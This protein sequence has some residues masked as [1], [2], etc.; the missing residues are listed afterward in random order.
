MI[1]VQIKPLSV[2]EAWQGKRFKTPK[3][4]KYERDLLFLLPKISLPLPPYRITFEF[5]LSSKLAD[6]D[7]PIK[8]TQ[9]VMQKKYGFNDKDIIEARVTKK[10]TKK[11]QEYFKFLIETV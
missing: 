9:D 10:L 11:G 4:S 8:P 2:N 3:Y 5:G 6:W 1:K 7:N